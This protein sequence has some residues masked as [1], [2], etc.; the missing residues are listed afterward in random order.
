MAAGDALLALQEPGGD[1]HEEQRREE[2]G[3]GVEP[4]DDIRARER[5]DHAA[6]DRPDERS[7]ASRSPAGATCPRRAPAPSTRFGTPASTAGRKNELAMPATAASATIAFGAV[8]ERQRANTTSRTTSAPTIS[9][10]RERRSTSGPA[11]RPTITVGRKVTMNRAL[12]P[13]G[14]IGALLDV[15]RERDRRD[16]RAE[17]GPE[18]R[19][20][21]QPEV[22][23]TERRLRRLSENRP[24]RA[25]PLT[26][27]RARVRARLRTG[28]AP[29]GCRP[30]CESPS[31]SRSPRA[32]GR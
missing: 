5:D 3:D 6:E 13:P 30:R 12:H 26:R 19:E 32:A 23:V 25:A 18:R 29:P 2:E 22:V 10:F 1:P 9:R 8:D 24:R 31:A 16:P 4:V 14:R 11:T 7:P 15:E 28:R 21:E 17:P 27:V 20:E